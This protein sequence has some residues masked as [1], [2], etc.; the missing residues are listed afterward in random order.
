MRGQD[1]LTLCLIVVSSSSSRSENEV[2]SPSRASRGVT[3]CLIGDVD[4]LP[5]LVQYTDGVV[6][7]MVRR[8]IE[9]HRSFD[10]PR[11]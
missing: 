8:W 9:Q 4:A 11:L 6:R 10:S 7:C 2:K 5:T 3:Y 1:D